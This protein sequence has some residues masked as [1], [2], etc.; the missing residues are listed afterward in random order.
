MRS[1]RRHRDSPFYYLTDVE[2]PF[3]TFIFD[4]IRGIARVFMWNTII[5]GLLNIFYITT[6][7]IAQVDTRAGGLLV[8]DGTGTNTAL[9]LKDENGLL[10]IW[11]IFNFALCM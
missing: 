11:A 1:K 5:H 9:Q 6:Y 2:V 3:I 7:I 4:D 8:D 10:T